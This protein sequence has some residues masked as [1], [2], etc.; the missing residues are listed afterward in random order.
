MESN[1][2]KQ[3]KD[4]MEKWNVKMDIIPTGQKLIKDNYFGNVNINTYKIVIKRNKKQMTIKEWGDSINS[5]EKG[6]IPTP[7]DIF[8][9]IQKTEVMYYEDFCDDYGYEK[10]DEHGGLNKDSDKIYLACLKE[11]EDVERVFGDNEECLE[12]LRNIQ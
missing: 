4:F 5:T 6:I 9:T 7:Y 11:W 3:V 8:S 12:E 10:Y 2:E 1:Y